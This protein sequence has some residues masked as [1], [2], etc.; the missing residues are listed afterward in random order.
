MAQT[1]KIN[2]NEKQFPDGEM[3]ANI[4]ELLNRMNI[5]QATVVAEVDGTIIE[6]KNFL[7][8]T[9]TPGQTIELIRFVGG[10]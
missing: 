8:T 3:P 6:R 9:L 7:G 10:G 1:L 5:D 2:G 4:S